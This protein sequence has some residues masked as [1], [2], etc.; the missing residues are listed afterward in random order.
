MANT[1]YVVKEAFSTTLRGLEV[2]YQV[3]E[4]V[5]ADD[6]GYKRAPGHF[7]PLAMRGAAS[8]APEVEQATAAPGEQRG[9]ALTTADLRPQKRGA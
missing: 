6:P 4:V 7:A 5:T 2:S 8:E 1:L 9:H 3:G